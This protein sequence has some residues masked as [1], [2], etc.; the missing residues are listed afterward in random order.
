METAAAEAE[1][2]SEYKAEGDEED[3]SSRS[4]ESMIEGEKRGEGV[5][6]PESGALAKSDAPETLQEKERLAVETDVTVQKSDTDRIEDT[7]PEIPAAQ[8]ERVYEITLTL[9]IGTPGTEEMRKPSASEAFKK[10]EP[11]DEYTGGF[12]GRT[13]PAR[14]RSSDSGDAASVND[15]IEFMPEGDELVL[16]LDALV[17]EHRGTILHFDYGREPSLLIS[18]E[19]TLPS[20]NLLSFV[21]KLDQIGA[22]ELPEQFE[23]PPDNSVTLRIQFEKTQQT[24]PAQ[25]TGR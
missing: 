9:D 21:E 23:V 16:L 24:E 22:A 19:V 5:A 6:E 3:I 17:R 15:E 25:Q 7:P 4:S 2:P 11:R 20:S 14:T 13:A 8:P 12:T 1:K 10:M 18:M